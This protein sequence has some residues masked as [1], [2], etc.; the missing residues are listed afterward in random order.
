MMDVREPHEPINRAENAGSTAALRELFAESETVSQLA[1]RY[2]EGRGL[3]VHI[4]YCSSKCT[5]CDFASTIGEGDE[6]DRYL[7]A[8]FLELETLSHA[9]EGERF[10]SVFIGGGTPTVL[11]AER[12][13]RLND[14][15]QTRFTFAAYIE[16]T[17]EANPE[18]AS[19]EVLRAARSSGVNRLSIG[20]QSFAAGTLR[21]LG[22]IHDAERTLVAVENARDA[23]FER[24]NID[25]IYGVPGQSPQEWRETLES[26]LDLEP[27]HLSV[28]GLILEHG[29][30]LELAV[31]AGHIPEPDEDRFL[32][33]DALTG[34][35]LS[36]AG[37]NRYE[38][39]NWCLDG[40]QCRHNL[41]YWLQAPWLG[42]G[43]AAHTFWRG[44]RYRHSRRIEPYVQQWLANGRVSGMMV[45]VHELESIDE[46]REAEDSIVFG[47]RLLD[48]LDGE[49]FQRRY[50]YRPQERWAN[51]I[52]LAIERGWLCAEGHRIRIPPEAIAISN[53]VLGLF[54]ETPFERKRRTR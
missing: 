18:S 44:R 2:G 40:R 27:E 32:E 34:D 24:L 35:R 26:A 4:P 5:Y 1:H 9:V 8:L 46:S 38:I 48:G 49:V 28:Y 45:D 53:E 15:I 54:V 6:I 43:V 37:F 13:K 16:W 21:L 19:R 29:T 47:L 41:L 25:L 12:L 31:Q 17:C 11:G 39:G 3:Y 36:H 30:P 50:G 20:A 10:T 42:V 14:V 7:E 52:E 22:R 23:G 51:E 33:M